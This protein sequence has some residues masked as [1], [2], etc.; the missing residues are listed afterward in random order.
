MV[1]RVFHLLLF[2]SPI[3][4]CAD[5][6]MD[7]ADIIFFRTGVMVLFITS[8][9]DKPKR[10]VPYYLR[11]IIVGLFGLCLFN[12]LN[13]SFAPIV[14]ANTMNIFLSIL[15]F[16]IVYL[17][18]DKSKDIKKYI[19]GAALI[20]LIFFIGQKI[21]FDPVFDKYPGGNLV[22]AFF[23]NHA[24]LTNYF[25]LVTPFL[26]VLLLP[27]AILFGLYVK[28]YVIFLPV[29]LILLL[30]SKSLLV[31]IGLIAVGILVLFLFKESIINSLNIRINGA[32][33]PVL[34]EFFDR[35]LI[36]CGIGINPVPYSKLGVILNSY[37]QLI[38]GA[39]I[40][41]LVWF[42]YIAKIIY[43]KIGLKGLT[44][45]FLTLILM[46]MIEYPT[47]MI[48]LWFLVIAILI[49]QLLKVEV[50]NE[51]G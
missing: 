43:E 44:F 50:I 19:L 1:T 5:V 35:P 41:A 51:T 42:G 31:K 17:Y 40:L 8:F 45:P 10:Q 24:R 11:N 32:W 33:L 47:E 9:L 36:G 28:Q 26:P 3:I 2:L 4:V 23:G 38:T 16:S 37:L 27:L 14:M 39:G 34:K 12:M 46:M 6:N 20:N 18:Y 48:R 30:K 22:G 15:G 29:F 13:H 7:M 21:G 25:T 49:M